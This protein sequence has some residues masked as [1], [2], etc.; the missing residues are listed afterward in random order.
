[1]SL[2]ARCIYLST[3]LAIS[4]LASTTAIA[5]DS[6]I[7]N[8]SVPTD[9]VT[10]LVFDSQAFSPNGGC[11]NSAG[12]ADQGKDSIR[13]IDTSGLGDN[14]FS[15]CTSY[16]GNTSSFPINAGTPTV[17]TEIPSGFVATKTTGPTSTS[18]LWT[19][20]GTNY[21]TMR[22]QRPSEGLRVCEKYK[23][24]SAAGSLL[25]GGVIDLPAG[26]IK[27]PIINSS[28]C[29]DNRAYYVYEGYSSVIDNSDIN[30][31]GAEYEIFIHNP[32]VRVFVTDD[33]QWTETSSGSHFQGSNFSV[34]NAAGKGS[35]KWIFSVPFSGD[36]RLSAGIPLSS[37]HFF[38]STANYEIKS[39]SGISD[40][41]VDQNSSAGADVILGEFYLQ[42][43]TEY[44][45]ELSDDTT[46]GGNAM[47]VADGIL[48]DR[49]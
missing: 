5:V 43:N 20:T 1:M 24:R 48:I 26:W 6:C 8:A 45:I 31:H 10:T 34:Y 22:L 25:S 35:F 42:A 13:Y 4:S 41:I 7:R 38:T 21:G 9:W 3:V 19:V 28:L 15:V 40:S 37:Q 30:S 46:T 47:L 27:G 2:Q 23:Y 16:P 36:Y 11:R 39:H 18:C 33:Y 17:K 14:A 44:Y 29:A 12:V 32:A 49:I